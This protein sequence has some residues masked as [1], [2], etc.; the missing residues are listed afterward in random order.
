MP[1]EFG[2]SS[3]LK[4]WHVTLQ[5][6]AIAQRAWPRK[7]LPESRQTNDVLLSNTYEINKTCTSKP[8]YSQ[9]FNALW[10]IQYP[11]GAP[12]FL[13]SEAEVNVRLSGSTTIICSMAPQSDKETLWCLDFNAW[14]VL[15]DT[16]NLTP[17]PSQASAFTTF[18][19]SWWWSLGAE[20]E[21]KGDWPKIMSLHPTIH[22]SHSDGFHVQA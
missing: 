16:I 18:G 22:I 17:L 13:G 3:L 14:I 10:V 20:T 15:L 2:Y 11:D 9:L 19:S 7:A 1:Q 21:S 8:F 12:S 4:A 5:Y 6:C